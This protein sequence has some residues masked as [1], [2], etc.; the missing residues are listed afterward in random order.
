MTDRLSIRKDSFDVID[1][2]DETNDKLTAYY[3]HSFK[4]EHALMFSDY[5][6]ASRQ[7]EEAERLL[8]YIS[9]ELEHAEFN[10]TLVLYYIT[11]LKC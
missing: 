1:S 2:I 7:Y 8:E 11:L 4:G 5:N 10:Q 3:Y 9:D 6:E